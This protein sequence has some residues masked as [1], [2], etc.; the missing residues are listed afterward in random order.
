MKKDSRLLRGTHNWKITRKNSSRKL[1]HF[2]SPAWLPSMPCANKTFVIISI[3]LKSYTIF[4]FI[5]YSTCDIFFAQRQAL[6]FILEIMTFKMSSIIRLEHE[7]QS[8]KFEWNSTHSSLSDNDYTNTNFS[9]FPYQQCS[10][11][12]VSESHSK[13]DRKTSRISQFCKFVVIKW[14]AKVYDVLVAIL[15]NSFIYLVVIFL[16]FDIADSM[17]NSHDNWIVQ[18]NIGSRKSELESCRLVEDCYIIS[19]LEF[20][21]EIPTANQVM[22]CARII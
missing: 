17:L 10:Q 4:A 18:K 21:Y 8:T 12:R 22:E 20:E 6:N 14:I 13:R 1:N 11:M 2:N 15:L 19:W 9:N 7:R 3:T 16:L 5:Q